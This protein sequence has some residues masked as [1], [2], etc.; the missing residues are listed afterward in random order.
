MEKPLASGRDADVYPLGESR[1]LRRYRA[2]GD[3]TP[4]ATVMTYVG[5]WGYPV[6]RVYAAS[7]PDLVLERLTGPTML[8]A[9]RAGQLTVAEAGAILAD[10]HGRLHTLPPRLGR[11]PG[12][13]VLHLDLHPLNVL[14]TAA[15]PVVIDWRNADEGP[16]ELDVA[17]TALI[18][19]WAALDPG[20]ELAEPARAMLAAFLAAADDALSRLDDAVA[21]RTRDPAFSAAERDRLPAAAALV[22]TLSP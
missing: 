5:G 21:R 17:L 10:L 14:M 2:G 15:G 13:R 1:V 4:E 19:A 3:V 12:D 9:V 8:D 22:R 18:L 16:A 20:S 6:P 7:G 11:R